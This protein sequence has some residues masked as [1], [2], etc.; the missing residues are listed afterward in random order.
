MR[1]SIDDVDLELAQ[2][3]YND[4]DEDGDYDFV[5]SKFN[6]TGFKIKNPN[7]LNK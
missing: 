7:S 1:I 2:L 4:N 3:V 5:K 6:S